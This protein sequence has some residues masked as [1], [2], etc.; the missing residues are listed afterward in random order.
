MIKKIL[1]R[2]FALTRLF[3]V[4]GIIVSLT[5]TLFM[6]LSEAGEKVPGAEGVSEVVISGKSE[7]FLIYDLIDKFN[8]AEVS[9]TLRTD[10]TP[11]SK[12]GGIAKDSIFQHPPA[13]EGTASM[14][15]ASLTMPAIDKGGLLVMTFHLG[16][17]DGAK[18]DDPANPADGVEYSV[19]ANNDTVFREKYRAKEWASR[20]V[21]LSRYAGKKVDI[22]LSVNA[23]ENGNYD[24]SLWGKPQIW[25]LKREL[26]EKGLS[27]FTN[28]TPKYQKGLLAIEYLPGF[29]TLGDENVRLTL[30][31]LNQDGRNTGK[32]EFIYSSDKTENNS[33]AVVE[34]DLRGAKVSS[35]NV[36]AE[37]M[38]KDMRSVKGI[39]I[40]KI[41][42]INY[43]AQIALRSFGP[44]VGLVNEG[45]AFNLQC[46]VHNI[47]E[48]PFGV[49]G[50]VSA[51]IILPEGLSLA[52]DKAKKTM[53][54]VAPGQEKKLLW[55]VRGA[56]SG[57]YKVGVEFSGDEINRIVHSTSMT[58]YPAIPVLTDKKDSRV[59]IYEYNKNLIMENETIR[60]V[61]VKGTSGF[62]YYLLYL[63][64]DS[65]WNLMG[66]SQPIGLVS[67]R[68]SSG[69]QQ[70]LNILPDEF[71]ILVDDGKEAGLR[72]T[73]SYHDSEG[74]SWA[75]SFE[76]SMQKSGSIVTARYTAVC[77][78]GKDLMKFNGPTLLVGEG[79]FGPNKDHALFPGLE[80]LE[81]DEYSSSTRAISAPLSRR[82]VPHPYKVTVP[83]MAVL[84]DQSL[85]SL[86]WDTQ[87]KWDG[88]NS[89]ISARFVSP[90][91]IDGQD[92]HFLGLFIPSV[93]KWVLENTN[94][95]E[96]AYRLNPNSPI[97]I[98][99]KIALKYPAEIVD[100]VPAWIEAYGLP[101]PAPKPRSFEEDIKLSREA[102]L[103]TLWDPQ[104]KSWC[105]VMTRGVRGNVSPSPGYA[106]LLWIDSILT[107]DKNLKEDI[108]KRVILAIDE[109]LQNMG[110]KGLASRGGGYAGTLAW[111]FPFHYG[112]LKE[113]LKGAES[114]VRSLIGSQSKDGRWGF[115]IMDEA[116]KGFGLGK[117][118]DAELGTCAYNANLILK[119]ARISG[120]ES[121]LQAGLKALHFMDRFS[122]P[123]G[124]QSWE[125]PLHA[126]D[127]VASARAIQ[128]YLEA[129]EITKEK[130]YLR[131]AVY[132]AK[133]SLPFL[134]LWQEPS[135]PLMR[136]ASIPVYGAT[137]FIYSWFGA[138]VQWC[139]LVYAY[140]IQKLSEYDQSLP[141]K[142]IAEGITV[143][144][145]YQT[146][147]EGAAEGCYTDAV[148]D[149][150]T[151]FSPLVLNPESKLTNIYRLLGHDPDISTKVISLNSSRL[152]ISSGGKV[153][154]AK[155]AGDKLM[156]TLEYFAGE[157]CYT[158]ITGLTKPGS[159]IKDNIEL[160]AVSSLEGTEEGWD[161]YAKDKYIFVKT[162]FKGPKINLVIN[163]IQTSGT[164][165]LADEAEKLAWD[166][167]A[168]FDTEGWGDE[169]Q[170][171]AS[172]AVAGGI[173]KSSV[174]GFD[175]FI[176][177]PEINVDAGKFKTVEIRLKASAG[178]NGW[179][180]FRTSESPE[181]GVPDKHVSF[182]LNSDNQF[183]DYV[184]DMSKH[185]NWK[186]NIL[187]LRVDI[188]PPNVKEGTQV[189]I[190]YIRLR[191]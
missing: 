188:E 38:G 59:S 123:R 173:L 91:W 100:A 12:S 33:I 161:Y 4:I 93:P 78:Q 113:S 50:S 15:Y 39:E 70:F 117:I 125:A 6:S 25:L 182:R 181:F 190:D 90:N 79:N 142:T 112:Y 110:P 85:I 156:L 116:S 130:E 20:G 58:V 128:A 186:G 53:G 189:E 19:L 71:K 153:Q 61:F 158:V 97:S 62:N 42:F 146:L 171:F 96:T 131:R 11:G 80:F 47:K 18:F 180:Y 88:K 122:V 32:K 107:K 187:Q 154:E 9:N 36:R 164:S 65:V 45:K 66:V 1:K 138:P 170:G 37:I 121:Y 151:T 179:V 81:R 89:L 124:A 14:R 55:A 104:K 183:H 35:V 162:K 157:S 29:T 17:Q 108:R 84:K 159:V 102:F 21:D 191:E 141:W 77:D 8:S 49:E 109:I 56:P 148:K 5:D 129:Y 82:W 105:D 140:S 103:N 7:I 48:N 118:G 76:F 168:D 34:Y 134:Y 184:V 13:A 2:L 106:Y 99:S 51:A 69:K 143:S 135:I 24:W 133:A 169:R 149:Y 136:Y 30:E 95:A 163:N 167:D 67:F 144:A 126:P 175:P 160:L 83:L 57:T 87:Y 52:E 26:I 166:F 60:V 54:E 155:V 152:H 137:Y 16:F 72:L 27:V 176:V 64:K 41:N 127:I 165:Q 10:V 28:I 98:E 119:Y 114:E 174:T 94:Q 172:P 3:L 139:G 73:K 22:S 120:K 150:F 31:L 75:F 147:T 40:G 115:F 63:Y 178:N 177:G 23:L 145:M 92:N 46:V 74:A 43:P 68:D 185:A 86:M 101:K 44:S 132:W 111:E